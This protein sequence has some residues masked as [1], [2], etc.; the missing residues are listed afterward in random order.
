MRNVSS[1]GA[2][3]IGVSGILTEYHGGLTLE[4]LHIYDHEYVYRLFFISQGVG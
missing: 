2:E 4:A 3:S 1:F